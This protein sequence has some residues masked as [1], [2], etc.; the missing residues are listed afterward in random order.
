MEFIVLNLKYPKI[1]RSLF[2]NVPLLIQKNYFNEV[3]KGTDEFD[4]PRK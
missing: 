1:S 3:E 4:I 2:N